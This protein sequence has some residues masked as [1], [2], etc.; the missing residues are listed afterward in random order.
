MAVE[1]AK[2]H[3]LRL[4]RHPADYPPRVKSLLEEGLACPPPQYRQ[5][6]ERQKHLREDMARCIGDLDALIMPATTGPAPSAETTG[7]PA[8][9]SPWSYT[10]L[11]SLSFPTGV[12]AEGMPLCIQ[13]VGSWRGEAKLLKAARWCELV[14]GVKPLSPWNV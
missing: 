2:F 4:K 7:N 1:A 11:P 3:H 13:L 14:L 5:C 12:F 10:G 9:N 8:F 6:I